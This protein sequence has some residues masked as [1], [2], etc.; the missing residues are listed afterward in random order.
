MN[1]ILIGDGIDVIMQ[2]SIGEKI[3]ETAPHKGDTQS[4]AISTGMCMGRNVCPAAAPK[5]WNICGV[6]TPRAIKSPQST[7]VC[8]AFSFLFIL[9]ALPFIV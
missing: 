9:F 3:P 5:R 6:S 4:P 1:G 2:L 7:I 8:A